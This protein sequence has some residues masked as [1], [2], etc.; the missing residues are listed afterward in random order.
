MIK[1]LKPR[2]KREIRIAKIKDFF[3][4]PSEQL[5]TQWWVI[6][7]LSWN[8]PYGDWFLNKKD[9]WWSR[10]TKTSWWNVI[11]GKHKGS[12]LRLRKPIW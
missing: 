7:E 12:K 9:T 6:N 3:E 4:K 2:S 1:H 11:T 5:P 8:S 10:W